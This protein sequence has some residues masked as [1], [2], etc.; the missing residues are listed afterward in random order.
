MSL[1]ITR[2]FVVPTW[3]LV[4]AFVVV[5]TSPPGPAATGLLVLFSGLAVLAIVLLRKST[6]NA[7]V[8]HGLPTIDVWPLSVTAVP[9]Q[10]RSGRPGPRSELSARP[11]FSWPNSGFRNIG[12]GT[13][14]G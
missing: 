13:K 5:W 7:R 4:C 3:L 14:R 9:Q 8:T 10:T 2:T 11:P 1:L 6:A 12:R